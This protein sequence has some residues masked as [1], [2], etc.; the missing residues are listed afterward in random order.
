LNTL[1]CSRHLDIKKY[2]CHNENS[3]NNISLT[4]LEDGG[5]TYIKGGQVR[6]GGSGT[7]TNILFKDSSGLDVDEGTHTLIIE[8]GNLVIDGDLSYGN[9]GVLGIMLIN[10]TYEDT[11]DNGNIFIN[12]EVTEFVG[13]YFADGSLTS[14]WKH[15]TDLSGQKPDFYESTPDFDRETIDYEDGNTLREQLILTGTLLT[16]NTLGGSQILNV[17]GPW[18]D[19]VWS[20]AVRYDLHHVRRYAPVY[21]PITDAHLNFGNCTKLDGSTCYENKHSFVIRI[22]ENIKNNPP[23]GFRTGENTSY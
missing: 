7:L 13:I 19:M 23:P 2:L 9:G 22:D 20:D 3:V 17:K 11:P 6:L 15:G 16:R 18:G 5:I 12:N 10:T 1:S 21:D 4:D 14:T 8:N